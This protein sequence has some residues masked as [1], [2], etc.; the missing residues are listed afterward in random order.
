MKMPFP[1]PAVFPPEILLHHILVPGTIYPQIRPEKN[2]EAPSLSW[3][4]NPN[5]P[6]S[7]KGG[8]CTFLATD[9]K[10]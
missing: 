6:Q 3:I 7:Q 8:S 5:F 1:A 4:A 9:T 10:I 2:F